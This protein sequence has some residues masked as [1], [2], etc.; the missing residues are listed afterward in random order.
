[1]YTEINCTIQFRDKIYG[2][3]PKSQTLLD[4]YIQ[5]AFGG[6]EGSE[7]H[8]HV[9]R[10]VNATDEAMEI[11]SCGFRQDDS[12]LYV[13][14][15]QIKAMIK[16]C[17]TLLKL[18]TKK[19]GVKSTLGE[20]LFIKGRF[21]NELVDSKVHFKPLRTQPDGYEDF[22]GNVTTAQ[23][24][25]SIL[26]RCEY[27]EKGTLEFQ[28]WL[29]EARFGGQSNLTLDD[30]KMILELGQEVGLGS[31]RSFEKGKFDVKLEEVNGG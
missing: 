28:I 6:E 4:K 16:Q 21:D 29:L 13:G 14:D 12:G 19:R 5:A 22:A 11:V 27:V 26:K 17:G 23:G 31:C 9:A 2:G 3:L 1:M 18:T 20:G 8:E 30:L 7:P 15:Y 25:R 10:D 24:P